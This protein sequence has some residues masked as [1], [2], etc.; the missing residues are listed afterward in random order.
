M[1]MM[2]SSTSW[3][4]TLAAR[5]SSTFAQQT[6]QKGAASFA[7][8]SKK[9][10]IT[11]YKRTTPSSK[12]EIVMAAEKETNGDD[13]N[14]SRE[15][16][17]NNKNTPMSD[18]EFAM[19]FAKLSKQFNIQGA[20]SM[21]ALVQ[22]EREQNAGQFESASSRDFRGLLAKRRLDTTQI[23]RYDEDKVHEVLR[24]KSLG[25][26][27]DDEEEESLANAEWLKR[28]ELVDM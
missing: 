1:M 20:D 24:K 22:R 27:F 14:K 6:K 21:E 15:N 7:T 19:A 8:A 23:K 16:D 28:Y 18:Q 17:G 25:L 3:R 26:K 11:K 10:S 4:R 2:F 5:P 12:K 13:V 9:E